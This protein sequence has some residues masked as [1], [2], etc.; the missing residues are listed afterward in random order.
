[1]KRWL[2]SS[3]VV[4]VLSAS[5][6]GA[7]QGAED[8]LTAEQAA[9]LSQPMPRA[10]LATDSFYFVM[11]DRYANGDPANDNGDA[12]MV[13]GLAS[14]GYKPADSGYFHGGDFVG[15]TANLERVRRMGFTAV[16]ITPPFVNRAVQSSSAAYHGYWGLDFTRIDPHL[17]TEAEF[18]AF[19]DKAKS[20]GLK[21]YL[22]IVMNHTADIIQYD[23]SAS[24][25]ATPR[26]N[27]YIPLGLEQSRA[28][29][30]LNQ[31]GNYHNQGAI[32][33]WNNVLQYRDGDFFSL[34]DVRTEN[35][36]VVD[37]FARVYA[38]WIID[39]GIDGFRIDT[40]KHVDD[41]FLTRWAARLTEYVREARP[42][43]EMSKDFDMFGEIYDE[44]A[45][46][47][48]GYMRERGLPSVLD[49]PMQKLLV[50][51]ASGYG[52]ASDFM[53]GFAWDDYYN[54]GDLGGR[55]ANAYSLATFT[56]NHDMG[57]IANLLGAAQES[58]RQLKFAMSVQFLMRG[59]PVVYY[60][61][62]VG[63]IGEAGDKAAR[64]DMFPTQVK[65]WQKE[66]RVGSEAIGTGSALTASALNHPL[67]KH[68]TALNALRA[69]YPA[70]A[71][72]A[73]I[74]RASK[75]KVAVWSRLDGVD[76]REF[77]V[78]ANAGG[79]NRVTVTT[80]TP[81]ALFTGVFGTTKSFRANAKG[82][83]TVALPGQSALVLRAG[84][85]LPAR[86][87][88]P[89]LPVTVERAPAIGK[90]IAVVKGARDPLTVTF[91]GRT[92]ATCEWQ[93]L[94]TDDAA[95][96]RLPVGMASFGGADVLEIA[97]IAR[98]SDGRTAAGPITRVTPAEV[99]LP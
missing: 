24:F 70:L 72:G 40:A 82:V 36:E 44:N 90:A 56:G 27:A 76:R 42:G 32:S 78:I 39:F 38:D 96:F 14:G 5:M 65:A 34:D 67:A 69:K 19:L 30:F 68:I 74:A 47:V 50:D 97:A 7:A 3:I 83:L 13:A 79:G 15:L 51:F 94:G 49:F 41:N 11:T 93:R 21:V 29:A 61:D 92:C 33:D 12:A 75:G 88:A 26:P 35:P 37:G 53:A 17:G 6:L 84:A 98:T 4:G 18:R 23:G 22:D 25:A 20:L 66:E 91:V 62:E 46:R 86:G 1:M 85:R 43:W 73:Q 45:T 99:G 55:L 16:W 80:S 63:M 57:R 54:V 89:E 60:G 58:S 87:A 48:S 81:G 64:Q 77:V 10:R 28:P 31:L 8:A 52:A 95:P 71:V 9:A 2:S 59:A